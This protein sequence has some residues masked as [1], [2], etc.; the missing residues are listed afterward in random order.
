MTKTQ[1]KE[2]ISK[3]LIS[4]LSEWFEDKPL[5]QAFGITIVQTNIN[6]FDGIIDM[7]TDEKGNVNTKQLVTNLGEE[8]IKDY[9]IDLRTISPLLPNRIIFISKEDI[10]EFLNQIK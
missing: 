3:K 6:K 10:T 2:I 8:V 5:I 9:S 4:L 7:L 1:L